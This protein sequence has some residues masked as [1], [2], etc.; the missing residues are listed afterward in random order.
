MTGKIWDK[1]IE[2]VSIPEI[3][4]KTLDSNGYGE[5]AIRNSK[6]KTAFNYHPE[7]RSWCCWS[8]GSAKHNCN[9]NGGDVISLYAHIHNI[10]R[11]EAIRD[12]A[13]EYKIPFK[14]KES[15]EEI[16]TKT[17]IE[18]IFI[19]FMI[20][21][22][23]NLKN[24]E[25][26]D[27]VIKK[28]GFTEETMEE[29]N[30]G[31]FDK[32][33]KKDIEKTYNN[34]EL[35]IAGF[36]SENNNWIIGKR[37][38]Y[39]YLDINGK[40]IYFIYR[41][42]DSE[43]DFNKNAKYV[44]Q[45]VT[46]FVQNMLFGYNSLKIFRDKPLIITE[47]MTDSISVIQAKYPCLSPIT[48]RLKKDDFE[49]A[50][51][52]CKRYEK[53]VIINDNEESH[54]GLKGAIDIL[55]FFLKNGIN[56][57]IN[58]IPN[59]ENLPKID[60]D[61]YLKKG[62]TINKQGKLLQDL[63]DTSFFGFDYLLEQINEKS[64]Q[65]EIENVLDL[66]PDNNLIQKNNI[67]EKIKDKTQLGKRDLE[68]IYRLIKGKQKEEELKIEKGGKKKVEK[69]N[70]DI[71]TEIIKTY[72]MYFPDEYRQGP[73]LVYK[74]GVYRERK[75]RYIESRIII[76]FEKNDM[77]ELLS[78]NI[79]NLIRK[80][81]ISKISCSILE[82][83]NYINLINVKNGILNISN[84]QNIKLLP[85]HSNFKMR[86]QLPIKYDIE[87]KSPKIEKL[88]KDIFGEKNEALVYEFMGDC[89]TGEI[90]HQKAPVLTGGGNN[91]KSTFLELL[92]IFIGFRNCSKVS[93]H[94]LESDKFAT[95]RLENKL[96]NLVDDLP[97]TPLKYTSIFKT[98]VGDKT[99][100]GQR[101]FGDRYMFKN[102][103]KHVFA[104]NN[105]PKTY[106]DSYAF[107]RRWM[108]INCGNVFNGNERDPNI[109]RKV[110]TPIELSGLLNKALEG[111]NRLEKRTRYDKKYYCTVESDWEI[112]S[113]PITEFIDKFCI[114]DEN[115]KVEQFELLDGYNKF[116]K[117][118]KLSTATAKKLSRELG[119]QGIKLKRKQIDGISYKN[120][121]GLKLKLID[122]NNKDEI[123]LDKL[124]KDDIVLD[125]KEF[126][127]FSKLLT[128]ILFDNMKKEE[129]YIEIEIESLI[130]R[131]EMEDFGREFIRKALKKTENA[132]NKFREIDGKLMFFGQFIKKPGKIVSKNE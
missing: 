115:F 18:A 124:I 125:E 10:D 19:D 67:I 129:K 6:S 96:V 69:N 41:L 94:D 106:D 20:K 81:I 49:N 68:K 90:K 92:K 101:K 4:P 42:I 99:L 105:I 9:I 75:T 2:S 65:E 21:C 86:M 17:K 25:Y 109:L 55:K 56:A 7:T 1:I 40:P 123:I 132:S 61:D 70:Y 131:L 83:D 85:H 79:I 43:P 128:E 44:K 127:R 37:I 88:I 130:E 15:K 114:M 76:Y 12:L 16:E 3:Y 95:S 111:L 107:F 5:C 66:I 11:W 108:I 29:F 98:V 91:G 30:I 39:P 24:S 97:L 62:D 50:I 47:G 31:L 87:F 122:E 119:E 71:A 80:I 110:C 78:I 64:K 26:Y 84:P 112:L 89:I 60:L 103:S 77:K 58:E 48:I 63:V 28:R 34:E 35:K 14:P 120:Y 126:K 72:P 102:R 74:D 121:I 59:P 104:C 23:N 33:V 8:C 13:K 27:F 51:H 22:Y 113:N 57:F 73:V 53:V 52:I 100:E 116:R 38:V 118:Q 54:E 117:D 93:L 46:D 36:K 82:F 32:S 45:K